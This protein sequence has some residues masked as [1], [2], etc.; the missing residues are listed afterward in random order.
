MAVLPDDGHRIRADRLDVVDARGRCIF[1]LLP[2][3]FLVWL[4]PHILMTASAGGARAGCPQQPKRI[5]AHVPV[6][7]IN[8]EF[9]GFFVGGDVGWFLVQYFSAG[10]SVS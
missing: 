10:P 6:V 7:P 2:K 3:N 9:P 5:D 1:E 8:G 4:R